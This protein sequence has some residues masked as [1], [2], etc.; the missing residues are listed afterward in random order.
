M[1]DAAASLGPG[2]D[3]VARRLGEWADGPGEIPARGWRLVLL[4]TWHAYGD[5]NVGLIAAGCAFYALLALFPALIA[6]I[7][8]YGLIADPSEIERQF[9]AVRH[10]LPAEAYTLLVDQMRSIA[11]R[12]NAG[13]GLGLIVSVA[14]ATWSATKGLRALFA[15]LNVVY[16][17]HEKR[18]LVVLYLQSVLFTVGALVAVIVAMAGI[19]AVPAVAAVV[20]LSDRQELV[21]D[22]VRWPLMAALVVSGLAA[23]YRYGPSRADARWQWVSWGSVAATLL[24]ILGSV[25]FSLY[26]EMAGSYE[27]TFGS[28]GAIVVLMLWLHL[29]ATAILLGAELNAALEHHTRVDSTTGRPRPMGERGAV[30][31]DTRP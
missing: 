9:S 12:D 8:L 19:V 29:G 28:M 26:V 18:N 20:G 22:L 15:G 1:T 14:V 4:R 2:E 30:V 5:H 23:L 6:V 13:L 21:L 3:P 11:A 25:L 10:L 16:R 7:S 17:E 27:S 31:A 24:W